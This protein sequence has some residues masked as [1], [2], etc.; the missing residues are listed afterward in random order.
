MISGLNRGVVGLDISHGSIA[1]RANEGVFKTLKNSLD[2]LVHYFNYIDQMNH[3]NLAKIKTLVSLLMDV[4][5][6]HL[7]DKVPRR[8]PIFNSLPSV[9]LLNHSTSLFLLSLLTIMEFKESVC[10]RS[11]E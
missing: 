5:F 4:H 3:L 10:E 6:G 8:N 9:L 7:S 11:E 1:L 2:Y